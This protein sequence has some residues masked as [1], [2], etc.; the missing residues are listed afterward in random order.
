MII[1]DTAARLGIDE[2][3]V[4]RESGVCAL[5]EDQGDT[6]QQQTGC[7]RLP[8]DVDESSEREEIEGL[9][10]GEEHR[11]D[12]ASS[13]EDGTCRQNATF[14]LGVVAQHCPAQTLAH[15]QAILFTVRGFAEKVGAGEPAMLEVNGDQRDI[16]LR[17]L[18]PERAEPE[19][20][21]E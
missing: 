12:G 9:G 21:K 5:D 16:V 18:E 2:A 3:A 1:S 10:S 4:R 8:L 7:Q 14:C 13:D 20:A 6:R 19:R 11:Q 17:R 15:M